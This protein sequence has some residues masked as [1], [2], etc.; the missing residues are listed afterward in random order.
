MSNATST[1]SWLRDSPEG[2]VDPQLPTASDIAPLT[3]KNLFKL[4]AAGKM[5]QAVRTRMLVAAQSRT[6][7]EQNL[8]TFQEPEAMEVN[9]A[10]WAAR[11]RL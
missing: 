6:Q 1:M 8:P 2:P 9:R 7:W 5:N 11:G 4:Q 10:T 3:K